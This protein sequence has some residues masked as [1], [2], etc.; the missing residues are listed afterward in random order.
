MKRLEKLFLIA[1]AV[2]VTSV[3]MQASTIF[4]RQY[5][6]SCS[7]CHV[8]FPP[9]MNNTGM[10]FMRNG[11]RFSKDDKTTLRAALDGEVV[12]VGFFAGGGYKKAD[13]SATTT[14][15]NPQTGQMMQKAVEKSNE[16][17][18]PTGNLF[19][20]GSLSENLSTFIGGK[21]A[22]Q[23]DENGD[24]EIKLLGKKI[25]L[26]A[27]LGETKHILRGG[28][29]S[30][31]N[32]FGNVSK[33]SENSGL[34]DVPN[35]FNSPLAMANTKAIH[36]LEYT[37]LSD[38]GI[39][40]LIAGGE[41]ANSND[42]TNIVAGVNYFN[43]NNFRISAIVNHITENDTQEQKALYEPSEAI[44]GERTT[45][46]IPIEYQFEYGFFNTAAVY[47]TNGL[48]KTG[49]KTDDYYGLESSVTVPMFDTGKIRFVYTNDHESDQGYSLSFAQLMFD[50][51]LIS[52]N[53]AKFKTDN[54]DFESILASI[55]YI[56]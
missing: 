14:V 21:Y 7:G 24:R 48:D 46:M 22:Y 9:M 55:S 2:V 28:F 34:S 19:V 10:E 32:Q 50:S 52:A 23:K 37:Y 8:G 33:A 36:G 3:S 42:E 47:T 56:Y 35:F 41:L 39:M 44:L 30:P 26:Q 31:Y 12:P 15:K 4:A 45:F 20:A 16:I 25:Y 13:L 38:N 17:T 18:N 40:L 54:A 27:N 53:A 5:N 11:M 51:V 43:G 29:I 49:N 1:I 6:M